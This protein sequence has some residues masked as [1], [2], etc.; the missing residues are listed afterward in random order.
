MGE[1]G[2]CVDKF[3]IYGSESE[4]FAACAKFP[5]DAPDGAVSG[6]SVQ[7]RT[8]HAILAQGPEGPEKHCPHAAPLGGGVCTNRSP[9]EAY[10]VFY[11]DRASLRAGELECPLVPALEDPTRLPD[12]K[13]VGAGIVFQGTGRFVPS[14]RCLEVCSQFAESGEPFEMSGDSANC[15]QQFYLLAHQIQPHH[16]SQLTPAQQERRD[17]LCANA[18][19]T[20]SL[21]CRGAQM[22]MFY[23]VREV[24][25]CKELCYAD[26]LACGS[27]YG[28]PETCLQ[29]CAALPA[30]GSRGDTSGD[31]VYCRLSWAQNAFFTQQT[32]PEKGKI[33]CAFAGEK[34]VVCQGSATPELHGRH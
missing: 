23:E 10:C 29:K 3:Q 4:C 28:T 18:H 6:D 17:S 13:I 20:D 26:W 8:E 1:N 16:G 27:S 2:V 25:P 19:P 15:R 5:D 33:F 22:N 21:M 32:E 9:C 24:F 14:S 34:S 11:Y 31:T 7:C 30:L 12:G